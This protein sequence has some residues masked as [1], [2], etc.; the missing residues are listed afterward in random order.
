MVFPTYEEGCRHLVGDTIGS[1]ARITSEVKHSDTV[2][3]PLLQKIET[4]E[5]KC[6]QLY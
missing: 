3:L 6:W 2:M 5:K 1:N 4:D